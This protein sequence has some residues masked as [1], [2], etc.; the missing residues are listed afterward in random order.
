MQTTVS[1][2]AATP[3]SLTSASI[4]AEAVTTIDAYQVENSSNL[5]NNNQTSTSN[6]SSSDLKYLHK[7]F[8]RIA[9]TNYV[10][11]DIPSTPSRQPLTEPTPT[12][13]TDRS[14]HFNGYS[15]KS[16]T[17][18]LPPPPPPPL[19]NGD[20]ALNQHSDLLLH[21]QLQ[22]HDRLLSTNADRNNHHRHHN[23]VASSSPSSIANHSD[24]NATCDLSRKKLSANSIASSGKAT[25]A[26]VA[27]DGSSQ[28]T[29]GVSN[30]PGR[31][32]CPFCQLN[33]TKPSVLR[34]HIRAH[35]NERPYPCVPCGFAFK[36]KSNL[37]K[38]YR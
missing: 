10:D 32:V 35:T 4:C 28:A 13:V 20:I 25:T 31:Y 11:T 2:T 18:P 12:V 36:T 6:C 21:Q 24:I 22:S 3:S 9:S 33:C 5:F 38:H 16:T 37:H 27:E 23:V 34:K 14:V 15:A 17:K 30:A 7:K 1:S 29:T 19:T 8:K 26:T